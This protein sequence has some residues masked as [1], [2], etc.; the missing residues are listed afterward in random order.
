MLAVRLHL[1]AGAPHTRRVDVDGSREQSR[2]GTGIGAFIREQ[3]EIAHVP[4][5]Q[6]A[7]VAGVSNHYL[8]QIERGL[9]KPSADILQQIA[10]GLQISGGAALHSRRV[11]RDAARRSGS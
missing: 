4:L 10:R 1:L 5:R 3:R 8:S 6:L 2:R 7:K 9:R 11:S